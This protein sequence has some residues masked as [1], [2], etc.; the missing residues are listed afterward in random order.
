[1]PPGD[2]HDSGELNLFAPEPAWDLPL[3]SRA[4]LEESLRSDDPE[5]RREA[6]EMLA[7]SLDDGL[8]MIALELA[9]CDPDEEIRAAAASVLSPA[10]AA[11]V[12]AEQEAGAPASPLSPAAAEAVRQGLRHLYYDS[13]S[14]KEV[15]RRALEASVQ[16]PGAWMEGA[17]RAA[18][19]SD[20]PEWRTTAVFCMTRLPG[21]A[22]E[23]LAALRDRQPSVRLEA[24]RAAG[25]SA[26]EAAASRLLAL[27][28][29]ADEEPLVRMAAMESLALL[30]D[31]EAIG[32]LREIATT[33]DP[34]LAFAARAALARLAQDV[35]HDEDELDEP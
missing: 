3:E 24:A 19:A 17:V 15:R 7:H 25:D 30:G 35:T 29:A 2:D 34:E 10:L 27:A 4:V 16:S 23:L 20:D 13:E 5:V 21:F 28:R 31:Q 11:A 12:A 6:V 14:P 1:M 18:W 22:D 26:L 9:R 8:A 32:P 33:A